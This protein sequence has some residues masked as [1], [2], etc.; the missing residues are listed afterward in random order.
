MSTKIK[1][2]KHI[3]Q[4]GYLQLEK[5]E[6]DEI[7]NNMEKGIREFFEK[8]FPEE[9]KIFNIKKDKA[10]KDHLEK[11]IQDANKE[12]EDD[13][14][15]LEVDSPD[16]RPDN[17]PDIKKMYRKI[18]EK[19]HPDKT[20][21][22]THA[23]IFSAAANAYK[24]HNVAKLLDLAAL[25]NIEFTDLSEETIKLLENNI[26]SI[27]KHIISKKST[28]AWAWHIAQND[29]EKKIVIQNILKIEDI[30]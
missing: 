29:E 7:C 27:Q 2:K 8:E 4:Y 1:I 6:V 12:E 11:N 13:M 26:T 23:E 17:N 19:T 9:F 5:Q 24:T 15:P 18:A 28:S 16:V 22:N 10:E 14:N 3:L 30:L 20:G 25:L 21:D